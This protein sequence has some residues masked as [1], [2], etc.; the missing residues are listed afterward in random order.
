MPGRR[1]P[2]KPDQHEPPPDELRDDK[3]PS[4]L[5]G[6]VR[7]SSRFGVTA[8]MPQMQL[9]CCLTVA[10]ATICSTV[11]RSLSRGMSLAGISGKVF[12]Q[13][14]APCVALKRV[15]K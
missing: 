6:S 9:G 3:R 13:T 1:L 14:T 10:V 7:A 11:A 8:A 5:V 2:P 12:L 4:E 15:R